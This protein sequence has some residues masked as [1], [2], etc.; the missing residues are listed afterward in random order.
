MDGI[1]TSYPKHLRLQLTDSL[2]GKRPGERQMTPAR[3]LVDR[4]VLG[5]PATAGVGGVRHGMRQR[6]PRSVKG[7]GEG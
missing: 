3:R 1:P 4:A 2:A 7:G 6:C 5:G